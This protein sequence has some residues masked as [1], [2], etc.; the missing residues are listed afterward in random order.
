MRSSLQKRKLLSVKYHFI[1]QLLTLYYSRVL[2]LLSALQTCSGLD[3]I[4]FLNMQGSYGIGVGVRSSFLLTFTC[5]LYEISRSFFQGINYI[6]ADLGAYPFVILNFLRNSQVKQS[7]FFVQS[8]TEPP[9][10][11]TH[12][13]P[14][15]PRSGH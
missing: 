5:T 3:L 4:S 13:V 10:S 12:H 7:D 11:P 2:G 6:E 14:R 1:M 9:F 8:M 15:Q